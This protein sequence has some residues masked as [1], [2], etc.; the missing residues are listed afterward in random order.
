AL[1][2]RSTGRGMEVATG[3]AED[4]LLLVEVNLDVLGVTP[5]QSAAIFD[6]MSEEAA[7][8][9]DIATFSTSSGMPLMGARRVRV[10]ADADVAYGRPAGADVVGSGYFETAGLELVAGSGFDT[11]DRGVAATRA[12]VNR[13]LAEQLWPG[14]S[15]LGRTLRLGEE[16]SAVDLTVIGVAG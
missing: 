2:V 7:A 6:R 10:A 1:F 11:R 4:E 15:P 8:L 14:E 13:A 9:P 16:G 12:V 3:Y 5:E